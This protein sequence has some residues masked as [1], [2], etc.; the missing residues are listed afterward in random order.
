VLAQSKNPG[1]YVGMYFRSTTAM[2][3]VIKFNDDGSTTFS[4]STV[5]G[6][7][8]VYFFAKGTALDIIR[9]Y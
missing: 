5:N 4:Y 1:E 7:L 6:V 3:A 8:D 9:L 2:S